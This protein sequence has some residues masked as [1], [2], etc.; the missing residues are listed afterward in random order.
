MHTKLMHRGSEMHKLMRDFCTVVESAHIAHG[1]CPWDKNERV[2]VDVQ[3][4]WKAL[5]HVSSDYVTLIY[6]LFLQ[7]LLLSTPANNFL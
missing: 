1:V 6:Y 2:H 7:I 4:T 5:Q 3:P